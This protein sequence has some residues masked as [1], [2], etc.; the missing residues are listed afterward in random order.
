MDDHLVPLG[1]DWALR[2]D[3]AV[4]SAG[5][6]V[7]GLDAFG[8]DDEQARL[9]D[10]AVDPAFREAVTW[11]NR[12]V[13]ASAVDGLLEAGGASSKGR[14]REE[15]VARY[16]QRYCS[17]N[18]TIGFF[19]PLAWGELRDNGPALTQHSRGLVRERTV[20]I[21]TWCLERFLQAFTEDPWLPLG[22][23]PEEDAQIR[24]ESI[25]DDTARDRATTGLARLEVARKRIAAASRDELGAALDEFDRVFE[26]P[27]ANRRFAPQSARAAVAPLS[28]WTRC[29]TLMSTSVPAWL[30]S[31]LLPLLRCWRVRGGCAGVASSWAAG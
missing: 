23:W 21:E 7:A 19:G 8:A 29:A 17:K 14:R 26:T 3:F 16:W 31:S 1:G 13:L 22:P 30:P 15:I 18:D 5:F 24:I 10:I 27:S 20:H 28:T 12:D 11:Q 9:H 6:P 2:R 4:R 25:A